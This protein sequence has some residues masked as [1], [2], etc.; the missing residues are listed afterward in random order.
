VRL[1]PI[2]RCGLRTENGAGWW[3]R[4]NCCAQVVILVNGDVCVPM[5]Y[6]CPTCSPADGPIE[7]AAP[8]HALRCEREARASERRAAMSRQR[9][10]ELD[11]KGFPAQARA[12][13]AD[14]VKAEAY[15]AD[16]RLQAEAWRKVTERRTA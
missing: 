9:A 1:L 11:A 6:V 4:C 13:E 5:P 16:L 14:A 7:D 12:N 10:A 3:L 8:G 2:K 15:A